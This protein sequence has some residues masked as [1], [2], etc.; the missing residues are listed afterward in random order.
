MQVRA[1]LYD[2]NG[3]IIELPETSEGKKDIKW[4]WYSR[5]NEDYLLSDLE[6]SNPLATLVCNTNELPPDNYFILKA[7]C[8]NNPKL[9]AYLPIPFKSK[10]VS[11]IEGAKEILYDY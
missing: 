8:G 6:A 1:I 5:S 3:H 9:E 2:I 10:N 7:E 4:S 11:Y